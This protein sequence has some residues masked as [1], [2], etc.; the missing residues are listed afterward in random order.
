[1]PPGTNGGIS[2]LGLLASFAGGAAI[3]LSAAI[4]LAL[5]QRCHGFPYEIVLIGAAAGL[6]G[7]LVRCHN[8]RVTS[9]CSAQPLYHFYQ[10]WFAI[11]RMI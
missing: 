5:E 10:L 7:S 6:V 9:L 3:G 11:N 4:T 2:Q 1:V 8:L